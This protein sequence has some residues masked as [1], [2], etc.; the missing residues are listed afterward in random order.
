MAGRIEKDSLGEKEVPL[1]AYY[2]I[3]TARAVENF[4]IS[5]MT[6]PRPLVTATILIKKAAAAA[7]RALGRLDADVADAIIGAAASGVSTAI[8]D[9]VQDA[10]VVMCSG[11]N[12]AASLSVYEPY[13]IRTAPSDELQAPTLGDVIIADGHSDVAVIWRNDEYGVGFGE[14]LA[15]YLEEAQRSARLYDASVPEPREELRRLRAKEQLSELEQRRLDWLEALNTPGLGMLDPEHTVFDDP[16][17][18]LDELRTG[19]DDGDRGPR[20]DSYGPMPGRK[21]RA[22]HLSEEGLV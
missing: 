18:R 20:Y 3:Q 16:R 21:Q 7:N 8:V 22:D 17:A 11:S 9:K 2:G 15:E 13:Y 14:A 10:G 1:E 6:A 19:G 4:P 12:T 5:G